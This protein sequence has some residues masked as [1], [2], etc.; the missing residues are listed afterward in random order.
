MLSD[1]AAR[2]A[3]V[4]AGCL[5]MAYTQLTM[6]PAA[7]EYA[8]SLGATGWHVGLLGALPTLMLVT[9]FAAAVVANRLRHRRPL[10]MAVSI[11]ERLLF[12]PAGLVALFPGT[13]SDSGELWL[14]IGLTAANHALLH[15][16]TPLWLSWMGD[17]LPRDG[18]SRFWGVRHNRMQWAGAAAL[19]AGAVFLR[20]SGWDFGPAF[21]VLLLVGAACGV[22]DI[23]FFTKV[24]EP[25]VTPADEPRWRDVFAAPFRHADFRRFIAYQCFWNFAVMVGSPF[26]GIY[27]IQKTGM[28]AD[29]LL[30]LWAVSWVGGAV[31]SQRIGR[32]VEVYGNKPMMNLCTAFKSLNIAAMLFLPTDADAAFWFLVPVFMFDSLL[33]AGNA[34]AH[35]GFLLKNSPSGNRTMFVAAGTALAGLVGGV[36]SVVSGGLIAAADGWTMRV[37][38][39]TWGPY[40]VAFAV[41]VALRIT[42]AVLSRYVTESTSSTTAVEVLV[43]LVGVTPMR[44]LRF[45]LGLYRSRFGEDRTTE[46]AGTTVTIPIEP[47][48]AVRPVR[49]R[50]RAA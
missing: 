30:L 38:D 21:G 23:L 13:L 36:T 10:W 9:Q 37:G 43:Q 39:A 48:P 4:F 29:R 19:L 47:D 41:C 12:V 8:R 26:I 32:L 49:E 28:T 25:P 11:A 27:L 33:N 46:P 18:L 16:C 22:A 1:A 14:F 2:R 3:I 34:I 24:F 5:G 31:L 15:F 35:N 20:R 6:S 17:Y 44:V 42:A 50:V 7:A 45:P 40:E